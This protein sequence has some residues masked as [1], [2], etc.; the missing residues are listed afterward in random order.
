[1]NVFSQLSRI[2]AFERKY[3]PHLLTRDDCDIMRIIG[4]YQERNEPLV[5]KQLFA[6]GISSNATV[7]RRIVKLREAGYLL[8]RTGSD[9]RSVRLF[10]SPQLHKT[11]RRYGT[12]LTTL[13]TAQRRIRNAG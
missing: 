10:L 11:Y 7:G 4:L 12:L 8:E 9:R 2:R 5:K 3:L 6:E 1:M 13:A